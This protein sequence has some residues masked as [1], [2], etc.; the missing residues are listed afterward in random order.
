MLFSAVAV[1]LNKVGLISPP[2]S[3]FI[4]RPAFTFRRDITG[5]LLLYGT[6]IWRALLDGIKY[7]YPDGALYLVGMAI[8]IL[9]LR[10]GYLLLRCCAVLPERTL[11]PAWEISVSFSRKRNRAAR[12]V[13]GGLGNLGVSVMQLVA[14]AVIFLPIFT[15]LGVHGVTQPDGSTMWLAMRRSSGYRCCCSPPS[16][17][18]SA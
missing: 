2:T 7:R 15:F 9:L 12:W 8:R 18:G 6:D 13:N 1:N 11:L 17:P 3:F 4:N 5:P 14:P 16:R 10:S